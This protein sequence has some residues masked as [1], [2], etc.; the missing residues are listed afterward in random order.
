LSLVFNYYSGNFATRRAS[1]YVSDLILDN[2]PVYDVGFIFVDGSIALFVFVITLLIYEPK[3][4][5]FVA[6]TLALFIFIR[7]IFISLTHLA[8][9]P[10]AL[11]LKH[12][13]LLEKITFGGDLFFSG[14]TGIPFLMALIFWENK[15]LR[16]IFIVISLIFAVTVLLGHLHYSIDVFA[17][18]FITHTIFYLAQKFFKKDYKFIYNNNN[19][20]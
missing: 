7:S 14:H 12:N 3:R 2:V 8:P 6:K 4:I 13:R 16:Y 5:P 10:D 11:L 17:A 15:P 18:Y 9:F 20:N 1:N 19:K